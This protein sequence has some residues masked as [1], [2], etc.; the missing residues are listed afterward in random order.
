MLTQNRR[1]MRSAVSKCVRHVNSQLRHSQNTSRFG[2]ATQSC[3]VSPPYRAARRRSRTSMPQAWPCSSPPAPS[4]TWPPSTSCLRWGEAATATAR[5]QATTAKDWA[6]WRCAPW[7]WAASSLWCCLLATTTRG[8]ARVQAL[9]AAQRG[10]VGGERHWMFFC[11]FA[12][13]VLLDLGEASWCL[14]C[15]APAT[16]LPETMSG[17]HTRELSPLSF[18]R[19]LVMVIVMVTSR[20]EKWDCCGRPRCFKTLVRTIVQLVNLLIQID[21][22]WFFLSSA[23][24][25]K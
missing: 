14:R 19:R 17:E 1:A 18:L 8:G 7:C 12:C 13:H 4:F 20:S 16:I 11:L 21:L 3:P 15:L 25:A 10:G 22:N 23:I 24:K 6:G 5:R 2:K 9:T